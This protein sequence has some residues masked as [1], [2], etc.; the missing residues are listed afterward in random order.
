MR[1]VP[2]IL[3]TATAVF[4]LSLGADIFLNNEGR[5]D[6]FLNRR[7]LPQRSS[8]FNSPLPGAE[9]FTKIAAD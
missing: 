9:S 3:V 1:R 6:K 5:L 4:G 2:R 8:D 7:L